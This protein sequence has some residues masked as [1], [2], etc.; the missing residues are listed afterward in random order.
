[1]DT[2]EELRGM[3]KDGYFEEKYRVAVWKVVEEE[4]GQRLQEL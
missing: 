2:V 1:V 4:R 3:V